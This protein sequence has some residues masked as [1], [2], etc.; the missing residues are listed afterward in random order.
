MDERMKQAAERGDINAMYQLIEE[1]E[2]LLDNIDHAPNL[3]RVFGNELITLLHYVVA[4]GDQHIDLLEKF[5]LVCP[6]SIRDV[7]GR[8]ETA[9]HI[10]LKKE[11]LKAFKFLVGWLGRNFLKNSLS[12]VKEVLDQKDD[13]GNTVLHIAVSK[14]LNQVVSH[15]LAWGFQFV[16][17]NSTNSKRK[18]A[19]DISQGQT[20]VDNTAWDISQEQT[21]VDNREIKL[22]LLSAGASSGSSLS[23]DNNIDEFYNLIGEDEKLL[24]H[25]DELPFFNT[26][27]HIAAS[28]GNIRFA[29]EMMS[30]K[31]S[32]AR[33]LN[34]NGFSP[35]HL[36]LRNKHKVLVR[37]LLQI[38]GDLV[39]VKGREC[40]TPLHYMV[41]SFED[42]ALLE[43][44]LEVCPDSITD[45]TVENKTALHIA[46]KYDKL[47]AFKLIVE[48]LAINCSE[49][50]QFNE[51]KVLGWRDNEGNTVLHI[52]VS[53]KKTQAS[54]LH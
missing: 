16:D 21:Q 51:R 37:K 29:L 34:Q 54:S 22:M 11:Q 13:E 43:L 35:I 14:N 53:E 50:D 8:K 45:V 10:A 24:E 41:E 28:Y 25:I 23:S 2:N 26:P 4:I 36:A 20:Q 48:W 3:F 31:P 5:L 17:V 30:L 15:L 6:D 12:N 27:L 7:T 39:R 33:K 19:W 46:L 42:L 47:K 49:N 1:E 9:L 52:A 38:D 44:F 32:F 40:L 18:T